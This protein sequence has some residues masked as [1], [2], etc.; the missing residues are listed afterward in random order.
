ML[1]GRYRT[2]QL[3]R[4]FSPGSDGNCSL[5]SEKLPGNIDHLLIECVS[6]VEVRRQ[7]LRK[8]EK[9]NISDISKS[10]ILSAM[11]SPNTKNSVQF[12]LDCSNNSN[13][14]SAVQLFGSNV[15]G[16]IFRF[17]RLWCYSVHKRKLKLQGR[18][19]KHN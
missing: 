9:D 18:W 10:L 13:V 12:L 14:I 3:V 1:S 2:D 4:H 11:N 6:L 15:L 16:E 8:L 17:T 5:C 7:L 19:T